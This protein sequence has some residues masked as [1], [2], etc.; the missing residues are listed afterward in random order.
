MSQVQM[1]NLPQTEYESTIYRNLKNLTNH[2][3]EMVEYED[4]ITELKIYIS[5]FTLDE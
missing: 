5:P 4:S 3:L 1:S 2:D